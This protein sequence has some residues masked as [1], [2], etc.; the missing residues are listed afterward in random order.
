[1][2]VVTHTSQAFLGVTMGCSKC[3]DHMYDPFPQTDYFSMRAIFESYQVRTDR[4]PGELDIM[5]AGLPRAYDASIEAKTYLFEAGDERY[6]VKDKPIP[7][8]IPAALGGEFQIESVKLPVKAYR[9]WRRE[10]V[11]NELLAVESKLMADAK[12]E[13]KKLAPDCDP[14]MRETVELKLESE[15]LKHA[16]LLAEF[17]SEALEDAG[18]KASD[19]WKAAA[20]KTFD[21]QRKAALANAKWKLVSGEVSRAKAE[22]SMA[23]AKA[24]KDKAKTTAAT[25]AMNK[26]K[27]DIA[28]AK[29]LMAAAEKQMKAKVTTEFKPRQGNYPNRS[30]G[31]RTAF[32]TWL[33]DSK[34][35]LTARVAMNHIWMRHFENGIVPTPNEFG[36]NGREPTHPAL[37][38]WLAAEFM[39]SGWSMKAMHKKIVLS[40]TFRQCGTPDETNL[41]VD[42]DNHFLWRMPSR[43][44][45]GEI[46]RDNLLWVSGRL[47]ETF[48]G[49][50]IPNTEA[51]KSVRR[52][53]YLRHAHE[54]LV[55]FVQIFDGPKVTECYVRHESVQPHQALA[56]H[57]SPLTKLAAE[58]LADELTGSEG[59]LED[60]FLKI[61]GRMPNA[62]EREAC[63]EFLKANAEGD[64]KRI[65]ERLITVLLNH[66][67]FVTVR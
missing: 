19:E 2:D 13:L 53:I 50:D 62:E 46:V 3:H 31:R 48:G 37:L 44:M 45:E 15:K 64:G 67:D 39:E 14:K 1:D 35:P 42:P 18:K 26:A 5:K 10:F 21:A 22:K 16:A 59:F 63:G 38:D 47:D 40:A 8:A 55:P 23:D 32:A 49:P 54:K 30:S 28:A 52:S 60:A 27:A 66:N 29:K 33:I 57:N 24:K 12:E 61:L 36:G 51:Q 25:R 7:P 17:E 9:P 4:V 43:R 11:R 65:R 20:E 56:M 34:N 41:A 58:K 6:P